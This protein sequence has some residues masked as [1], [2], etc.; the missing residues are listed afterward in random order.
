MLQLAE[1]KKKIKFLSISLLGTGSGYPPGWES[2][3][4][5]LKSFTNTSSGVVTWQQ[6]EPACRLYFSSPDR[7]VDEATPF[8]RFKFS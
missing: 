3:P 7:Q 8:C 1:S 5:L 2:I 6:T 4:R